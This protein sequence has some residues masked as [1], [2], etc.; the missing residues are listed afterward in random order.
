MTNRPVKFLTLA[1]GN[2]KRVYNTGRAEMQPFV[3]GTERLGADCSGVGDYALRHS[4]VLPATVCRHTP[5]FWNTEI[6]FQSL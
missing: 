5:Y 1:A 2:C 4:K 3:H 6:M